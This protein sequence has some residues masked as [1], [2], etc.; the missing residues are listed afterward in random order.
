M[1][2][3]TS[4]TGITDTSL[5]SHNYLRHRNH[6]CFPTE[7]IY[8]RRRHRKRRYYLVDHNL[9]QDNQ[10]LMA[11]E[12]SHFTLRGSTLF[13]YGGVSLFLLNKHVGICVAVCAAVHVIGTQLHFALQQEVPWPCFL[14]HGSTSSVTVVL[15]IAC[16]FLFLSELPWPCQQAALRPALRGPFQRLLLQAK[17]SPGHCSGR[18]LSPQQW[19]PWASGLKVTGAP[20]TANPKNARVNACRVTG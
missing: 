13:A 5:T 17:D 11:T 10:I 9:H 7:N 20:S 1:A 2:T 6:G 19:R 4:V 14:S 8:L 16:M 18:P 12:H 15:V 3:T